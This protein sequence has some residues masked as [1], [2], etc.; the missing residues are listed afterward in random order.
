[1]TIMEVDS[2]RTI[3]LPTLSR[4]VASRDAL[5]FLRPDES[6]PESYRKI[7]ERVTESLEGRER[8]SFAGW[9]T[10]E[11]FAV[12]MVVVPPGDA[13]LVIAFAV[14]LGPRF[15]LFELPGS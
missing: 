12:A 10:D 9:G 5:F 8:Y 11:E 1:M 6:R 2:L 13:A 14:P 7:A 3:R 4:I 15:R